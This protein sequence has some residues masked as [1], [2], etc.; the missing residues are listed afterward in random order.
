MKITAANLDQFTFQEYG[1]LG[2]TRVSDETLETGTVVA[3][4]EGDFICGSPSRL[5]IDA[6]G[7]IYPVAES[8]F[9]KT[10]VACSHGENHIRTWQEVRDLGDGM[11]EA[12]LFHVSYSGAPEG[13]A[14]AARALL[15]PAIGKTGSFE[16]QL[17]GVINAHS[18]E[19][20]SYT[21][22][23]I[24]S[25]YLLGC[26]AAFNQAV[27]QRETWYRLNRSP[28]NGGTILDPIVDSPKPTD[29]GAE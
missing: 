10:Y 2:T 15:G 25:Q 19:S 12:G 9:R 7:N 14:E 16:E 29:S 4:L 18:Q 8:I 17:R 24:L 27:L 28:G 1:K 21:P 26:L 13:F 6:K 22:D 5:A 20:V 11:L 23:Y 3:T